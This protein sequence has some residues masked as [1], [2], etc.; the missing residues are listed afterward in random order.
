MKAPILEQFSPPKQGGR[1]RRFTTEQKQSLL[2]EANRPG[3]RLSGLARPYRIPQ[4]L[5]FRWRQL[6]HEGT[7][8]CL[9]ADERIV[10]ATEVKQLRTR[11]RE[12]ERLLGKKT[13]EVEIIHAP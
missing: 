9:D 2:D 5:T 1:R 13:M 4:A 10:A 12:L 3:S 6:Q 11:V 8:V 7:L